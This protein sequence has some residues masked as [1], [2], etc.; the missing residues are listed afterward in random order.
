MSRKFIK[1]TDL[2][3]HKPVLLPV[4]QIENVVVNKDSCTSILFRLNVGEKGYE[5]YWVRESVDDIYAMLS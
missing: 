5:R 4:D 1:V 3:T 2:N